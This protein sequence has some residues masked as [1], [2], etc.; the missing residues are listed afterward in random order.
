MEW[1]RDRC[2]EGERTKFGTLQGFTFV[3]RLV[4]EKVYPKMREA[5]EKDVVDEG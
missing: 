5:E 2:Q 4:K 3:N 1:L